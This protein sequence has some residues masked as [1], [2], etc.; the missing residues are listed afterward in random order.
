MAILRPSGGDGFAGARTAGGI[1][2]AAGRNVNR[3]SDADA[4]EIAERAA[5][6]SRPRLPDNGR[7]NTISTTAYKP[8]AVKPNEKLTGAV[9]PRG[10]SVVKPTAGIKKPS[11]ASTT[12]KAFGG[13]TVPQGTREVIKN[14]MDKGTLS[15]PKIQPAVIPR[16]QSVRPPVAPGVRAWTPT[17]PR[18]VAKPSL[19]KATAPLAKGASVP[20][21]VKP[22]VARTTIRVVQ[23]KP[24]AP[25]STND[26]IKNGV[27]PRSQAKQETTPK[28]NPGRISTRETRALGG[29]H[30]G[31]HSDISMNIAGGGGSM[32]EQTR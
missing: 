28:L 5:G 29:Q 10:E 27:P 14:Q 18:P 8:V 12:Y 13:G 4:R 26:L 15:A 22:T 2:G 11:L 17:N 19:P 16:S 25:A 7:T 21:V 1:S 9:K 30:M 31:G 32:H 23:Q 3:V 6:G 20:A 24:A